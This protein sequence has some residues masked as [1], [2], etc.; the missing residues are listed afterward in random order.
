M[1]LWVGTRKGAFRFERQAGTWRVADVAFLGDPVNLVSV[2]PRDGAVYAALDLGHY[3]SKLH[4]STDG[5]KSFE[6]LAMPAFPPM[7]EGED[8]LDAQGREV[9]WNVQ[10]IWALSPGHASQPGRLWAGTIP[11]GLFRSDDGGQSWQLNEALWNMP[12]RKQ[13]FGGGSDY[14]A[15]HSVLVHPEHPERVLVGISCGG[16]WLSEDD[17][18]SWSVRAHG[19]RADFLPPDQAGNPITQDP[20]CIVQCAAQPEVLWTQHHCG[21]FRSTDGGAQWK[22]LSGVPVSAFGFPVAVHPRD[23]DTAWFVPAVKDSQRVPVD[24]RVVVTRT[25]DGGESFDVLTEGLPSEHAYDIVYR[26][27]L[28]VDASG[29]CLAFG[30]TTGSLWFSDDQGDRWATLGTHLPPIYSVCF[31]G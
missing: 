2:D 4:R 15:L 11:G 1:R 13:W 27:A 29:D 9:P 16:A 28:D 14:P 26:H 6:E 17:G 12:E 25:R 30:S 24:A 19:M 18:A 31:A 21:I 8:G 10:A 7:P 22:E 3:G 23:P 20:H 5:G